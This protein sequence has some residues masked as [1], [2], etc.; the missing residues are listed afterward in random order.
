MPGYTLQRILNEG[1]FTADVRQSPK[2]R[3]SV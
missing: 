2:I 1:L 3:S